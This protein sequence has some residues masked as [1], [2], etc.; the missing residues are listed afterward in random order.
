VIKALQ[1]EAVKVNV[2]SR[3]VQ[4]GDLPLTVAQ[5]LVTTHEAI[6]QQRA[7]GQVHV[8]LDDGSVRRNLPDFA[9]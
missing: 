5:V 8:G 9:D 4:F 1:G 7:G 2:V 6:E 3:H